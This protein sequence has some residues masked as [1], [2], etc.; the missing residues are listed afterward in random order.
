MSGISPLEPIDK[1]IRRCFLRFGEG[2]WRQVVGR[3][4]GMQINHPHLR[5][6]SRC[7]HHYLRV[8]A[9]DL[10]LFSSDGYS[11]DGRRSYLLDWMPF[12][13]ADKGGLYLNFTR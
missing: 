7:G 5:G 9:S 2:L 11:G 3:F 13:Q 12:I 6:G 1:M 8:R 10:I 4:I